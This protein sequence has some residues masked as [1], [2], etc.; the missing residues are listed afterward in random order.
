MKCAESS[1]RVVAGWQSTVI[2]IRVE[3]AAKLTQH[4][5]V[6]KTNSNPGFHI[7]PQELRTKT[8]TRA[9]GLRVT[10]NRSEN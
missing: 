6:A 1:T 4:H 5:H 3:F 8:R 9:G 10:A 7:D 2:A